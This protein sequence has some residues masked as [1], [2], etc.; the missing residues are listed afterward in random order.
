MQRSAMER[1]AADE[2]RGGERPIPCAK[3]KQ[4]R[5]D[6]RVSVSVHQPN[7]NAAVTSGA[8]TVY[9]SDESGSSLRLWA[10]R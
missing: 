8:S 4:P 7:N 9:S 3:F 5:I 2:D 10:T 6:K 1:K